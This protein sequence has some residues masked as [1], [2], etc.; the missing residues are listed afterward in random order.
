MK[1]RV[2]RFT[3]VTL[4][5]SDILRN[6]SNRKSTGPFPGSW[7][8]VELPIPSGHEYG[9]D[10]VGKMDS[11]IAKKFE[12]KWGVYKNDVSGKLVVFFEDGNDAIMFKLMGG[13]SAY[14]ENQTEE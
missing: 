4:K 12:S 9:I 13:E 14:L 6:Y 3:G 7:E 5:A 10:I 11:Y 8:R 2:V 1:D